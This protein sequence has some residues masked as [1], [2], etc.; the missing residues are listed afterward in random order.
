MEIEEKL[1]ESKWVIETIAEMHTAL[2]QVADLMGECLKGG[3]K[4]I[5][6]GNGGSASQAMHLTGELAGRFAKERRGLASLTIGVN[7]TLVTCIGN[8]YGFEKV[9]SR[10]L[11][12]IGQ[13]KDLLIAFTTSGKSKNVVKAIE[14]A[15]EIGMN[16][17]CFTSELGA[18]LLDCDVV[19]GI[20][21]N[22]TARI[23]EAHLV[24]VHLIC[25]HFDN[26]Y[27][28]D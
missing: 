11:E 28:E 2:T 21:S 17:I 13:E 5:S 12:S 15:K 18:K 23:Q 8:D 6:C 25:E 20:K 16:T 22:S 9:F 3:G 27:G 7:S 19:L 14:V 10:E 26:V 24:C 4:I 1:R